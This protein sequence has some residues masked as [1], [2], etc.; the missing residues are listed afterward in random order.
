MFPDQVVFNGVKSCV[1][2][3]RKPGDDL[4]FAITELFSKFEKNYGELPKL[5]LLANHGIITF[6][7]TIEECIVKTEICEKAAE[8]YLGGL[9][10]GKINFLS[11]FDIDNIISD[12]K[13]S[14]R[15]NLLK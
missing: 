7:S 3:Y 2:P 6:G 15:F 4:T 10:I 13:E 12:S 14:Y 8:I 5:L 11:D 9:A 1:I